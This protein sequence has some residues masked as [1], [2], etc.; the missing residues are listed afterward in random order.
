[1]I[2]P[3]TAQ[4]PLSTLGRDDLFF[5]VGCQRSGT[6]LMR[7]ILDC[8]ERIRCL[9][10]SMSYAAIGGRCSVLN[11]EARMLGLKV[12]CLTEQLA[13]D[14]LWDP[15]LLA[16]T[17][18]VYDRHRAL[19]MVRDVRDTI[20][21]MLALRTSGAPWL[22]IYLRPC[23]MA[24][25]RHEPAFARRYAAELGRVKQ[26]RHPRLARAALYWRYKTEVLFDYLDRGF[27]V[28]LVRYEDLVRQAS[29]ELLRV[30]GF[31]QV[32]WEAGLLEHAVF[33]HGELNADGT[34]VGGTDAHRPIDSRSLGRWQQV[35]SQDELEEIVTFAGEPFRRLYPDAARD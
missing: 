29:I 6:T 9:D 4:P 1:V 28:L 32:R 11:R 20:A 34:A 26:A 27:P 7:L 10:E 19:F 12:P 30:C 24:K 23:L 21:S 16:R 33:A 3:R 18:N 25:S 8:H 14:S 35:F 2:E 15:V 31:L 5:I 13:N 17:P 22:D